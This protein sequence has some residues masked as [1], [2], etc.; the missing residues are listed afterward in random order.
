LA[1]PRADS[2]QMDASPS[3]PAGGADSLALL[4]EWEQYLESNDLAESTIRDYVLGM[5]RLL[6]HMRR[7]TKGARLHPFD[8]THSDVGAFLAS[9]GNRSTAKAQYAKGPKSFYSYFTAIGYMLIDP[10]RLVRSPRK[11]RLQ[12]AKDAFTREELV[13]LLIAAAHRDPRRAWAILACLGLG[14]R[15]TEFVSLHLEDID[16]DRGRVDVHR[17]TKGG[18]RRPVPIG[19]WA[20]I[21][22]RELEAAAMTWRNSD[23]ERLLPVEPNVLNDWMKDAARDCGFTG[24]RKHRPHTLRATAITEML[25]AGLPPH[26]V[27]EIVGHEKISTTSAYAVVRTEEAK[28]DAVAVLGGGV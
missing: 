1:Q 11:S 27:A 12:T 17:N 7:A 18:K 19:P 26:V 24:A 14:M 9:L 8:V 22:L 21:A 25:D 28:S 16:W 23:G 20:E 10:T 3:T 5:E 15:R 4:W 6:R 13:R 2:A